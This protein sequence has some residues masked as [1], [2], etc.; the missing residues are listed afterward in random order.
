VSTIEDSLAA[1]NGPRL[2]NRSNFFI[3]IGVLVAVG[4]GVALRF[5]TKS[6]LWLDEAL[7]VNIARLPLSDIQPALRRDGA[8]PLF[9]VL[10]HFWIELFG[11]SD[12]AVRSLSGL[13]SVASLPL[14]YLAGL[15]LAGRDKG[16]DKSH[17]KSPD[18]S[19]GLAV[20]AV[21]VLVSS[22]YA[23]RYATEAR[24]YS[25]VIFLVFWGYLALRRAF[26]SPSVVRLAVVALVTALLL[27][28]QYWSLYLVAVVGLG[29]I[30]SLIRKRGFSPTIIKVLIAIGAGCLLF[31][32]WLPTFFYQL[33]HT[34][35][36]WGNPQVPWSSL[37]DAVIAFAGSEVHATAFLLVIPLLLLPLL[38]LFGKAAGSHQVDLDLHTRPEA[39]WEIVTAF[40]VLILGLTV[41]WVGGTAF[42]GR[43]AAI[44][45]PLVVLVVAFGLM[46]FA[47]N[48]V[49]T[50][51]L[52]VV[53]VLG[54]LT[55]VH[56]L[57]DNRTQAGESA[58]LIRSESKPRDVVIYC[59]DQL[60]PAVSRLLDGLPVKQYTFP[61]LDSPALI[62]WVDYKNRIDTANIEKIAQTVV[63]RAG[64]K[65]I[66]LVN[67][68]AYENVFGKCGELGT[69]I[70][71]DRD[72]ETL[73]VP[74]SK[75]L[76]EAQGLTVFRS[77]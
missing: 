2:R 60:G 32:P 11:T 71:Q 30:G 69:A 4:A 38:A 16:P 75:V 1:K 3:I 61:A 58:E 41:S 23:I 25:L 34:G 36:P 18:K 59:P 37:A 68:S 51:V 27:Y 39:R 44:V 9:Y 74:N 46:V 45:F 43:Y 28:T 22:P 53:V 72:P 20:A 47:D 76:E 56:N 57:G 52:I 21:L 77:P 35:T 6:D 63:S 70:A 54:F 19:Q 10:L 67:S 50:G 17:D 42:D 49:R 12:T 13:L 66:F 29:L 24:M 8:P 62:N 31:I 14:A 26:D 55:A 73:A 64:N 7:S 15:R 40:A 33:G 48:R 65:T 5:I